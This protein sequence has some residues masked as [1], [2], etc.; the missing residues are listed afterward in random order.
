MDQIMEKLLSLL[1]ERDYSISSDN[2]ITIFYP[3][4][5]PQYK[6][7]VQLQMIDDNTVKVS[8]YSIFSTM[9]LEIKSCSKEDIFDLDSFKL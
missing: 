5:D 1:K 6:Y 9:L 8:H 4:K 2:T 3:Q 7:E